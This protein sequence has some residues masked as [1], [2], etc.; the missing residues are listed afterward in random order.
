MK[1]FLMILGFRPQLAKEAPFGLRGPRWSLS[2]FSLI[3][4]NINL[5]RES[6]AGGLTLPH[7]FRC[8]K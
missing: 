8:G 2:P 7:T 3:S 6:R 4:F 1:D 5:L